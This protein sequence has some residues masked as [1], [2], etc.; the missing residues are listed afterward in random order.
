MSSIATELRR[1]ADHVAKMRTRAVQGS[2]L[3]DELSS[4]STALH[5]LAQRV[6]AI[7]SALEQDPRGPFDPRD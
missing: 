7:V 2:D 5:T 6:E 4:V 3:N 1:L